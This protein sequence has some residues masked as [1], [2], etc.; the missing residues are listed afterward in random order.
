MEHKV[1]RERRSVGYRARLS[2]R[3]DRLRRTIR[4]ENEALFTSER[5][6]R[7]DRLEERREEVTHLVEI[8][9]RAAR[10]ENARDDAAARAAEVEQRRDTVARSLADQRSE[11]LE[12]A[13][14]ELGQRRQLLGQIS[15]EVDD[16]AS[17]TRH[18]IAAE[19]QARV[20]ACLAD[21]Q[22]R[23]REIAARCGYIEDLKAETAEDLRRLSSETETACTEL[24]DRRHRHLSAVFS[25]VDEFTGRY[26]E[27]SIPG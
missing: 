15:S 24:R 14:E 7:L 16:A 3:V 26:P 22:R 11:R 12:I 23:E 27:R 1:G 25:W 20:A 5:R 10:L 17:R 21:G 2:A 8:E 4:A 18:R 19:E 9:L 13:E 6:A